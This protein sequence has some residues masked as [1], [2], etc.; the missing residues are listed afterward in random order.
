ATLREAVTEIIDRYKIASL[1]VTRSEK[2]LS[3]VTEDQDIVIPTEA[4]EVFDV[5][6]AGDTVVA[7]LA[8]AM[9]A[10]LP[11]NDSIFLANKA[12][13]VVVGKMGTSPILFHELRTVISA[14]LQG[15]DKI[16]SRENLEE[17]LQLL[18][19]HHSS[20]VFTNGCFDILHRGHVTY[21]E[22]AKALGDTLIL[23]LNSDS[24]VR[25]L[26]GEGRPV[27][28][29]LSRATVMAALSSVDYVVIFDE[30]TPYELIKAIKPDTLVK[31]GDYAID[32]IVGREFA[33][34]TTTIPFVDGFSTTNVLSKLSE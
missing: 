14:N 26:K 23:G 19:A 5:S 34:H 30:D 3:Y 9:G 4:R 16:V 17:L 15:G 8:A 13:G 27:N 31:G 20:V 28:D 18:R 22:R 2:G 29:E 32:Q 24:S 7:T 12:A 6:G 25:R 21:L 1:L 33:T 10:G 11:I